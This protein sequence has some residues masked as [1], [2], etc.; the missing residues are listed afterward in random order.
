MH[1]LGLLDPLYRESAQKPGDQDPAAK[2][3]IVDRIVTLQVDPGGD[4]LL[5]RPG[6]AFVGIGEAHVAEM[7]ACRLQRLAPVQAVERQAS[8]PDLLERP[9]KPFDLP[10]PDLHVAIGTG[11]PVDGDTAL[12]QMDGDALDV[13]AALRQARLDAPG[14]VVLGKWHGDRAGPHE[15]NE[16]RG[17][18]DNGFL[19]GSASGCFEGWAASKAG[20]FMQVS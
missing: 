6:P 12:E 10:A 4:H 13:D 17:N 15:N 7:Q 2:R 5:D 14:G 16:E 1:K 18:N 19:H 11:H 20:C 3:A 9:G 8:L